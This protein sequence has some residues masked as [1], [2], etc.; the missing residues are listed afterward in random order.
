MFHGSANRLYLRGTSS[1]PRSTWA[2]LYGGPVLSRTRSR[3]PS[4]KEQTMSA[5][6]APAT[7]T[8]RSPVDQR[9]GGSRAAR[10]HVPRS[11]GPVDQGDRGQAA[12]DGCARRRRAPAPLQTARRRE[13][14]PGVDPSGRGSAGGG[15]VRLA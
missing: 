7:P 3:Y 9:E 5:T 8:D 12:Q 1:S 4:P 14:G 15:G 2:D 6:T 13:A 11:M 10:R